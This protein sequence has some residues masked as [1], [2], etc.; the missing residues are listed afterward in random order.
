[1]VN[2]IVVQSVSKKFR[3]YHSDRPRTLQEAFVRGSRRVRPVEDFWALRDVSFSVSRGRMV[4]VVGANGSGKS[5]LLRLIGSVGRPDKGR[6]EV[7]GRLGAL[8][9]LSTGFH[10]ELTGRDNIFIAGIIAG[11]RRREVAQRFDSIVAFA[12]LEE[13]IDNPMRTYSTGMQMRLG[14]AVAVHTEP[15]ILLIEEIL[16]VGDH[17]FQR[18]C[19]DRIAQFK[20]DGCTIILVSHDTEL[21]RDI[22]DEALWLNRGQLMIHGRP[23]IVVGQYLA[24]VDAE[25][26]RRDL[27]DMETRRRTPKLGPVT[28]TPQGN[29]LILN[30]NRF[31]S[32][33]LEMTAVRLV[34]RKGRCVVEVESGEPLRVEIDFWVSSPVEAPIFEV[35]ISR[36]DGLVCYDLDTESDGAKLGTVESKGHIALQIDRLDLSSGVYYVTVGAYVRDWSYAY[37]YHFPAYSLIVRGVTSRF[38]SPSLHRWEISS[39]D[40]GSYPS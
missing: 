39:R 29:E 28:T 20:A 21:V 14:F 22:C 30:V 34:D 40:T 10:P 32:L 12:E 33:E 8:L 23:N 9:D 17:A 18:K 1:M 7:H 27:V 2:P 16:S 38:D 35:H 3:R 37:D 24:E 19:L 26:S 31:G 6:I 13:F 15:Q 4:G 25:I 36:V 5:T 11:L